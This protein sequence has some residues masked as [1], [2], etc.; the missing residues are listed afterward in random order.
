L[1]AATNRIL[2]SRRQLG[3]GRQGASLTGY[4]LLLLLGVLRHHVNPAI[5]PRQFVLQPGNMQF[6][7]ATDAFVK[8]LTAKRQPIDSQHGDAEITEKQNRR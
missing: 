8:N 7:D 5:D 3:R 1:I 6:T 2:A 4:R